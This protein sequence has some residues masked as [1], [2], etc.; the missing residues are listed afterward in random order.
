MGFLRF[1]SR[2]QERKVDDEL[3]IPP[4]PP[5]SMSGID[6]DLNAPFPGDEL[7][8]GLSFP[9][10]A[11]KQQVQQNKGLPSM[12]DFDFDTPSARP[13][14]EMNMQ[15]P[16]ATPLQMSS[17]SFGSQNSQ[18]PIIPA[19]MPAPNAPEQFGRALYVEVEQFRDM[20]NDLTKT[21]NDL[22]KMESVMEHML[23]TESNRD[24]DY[25]RYRGILNDTQR[26]LVF[27]DK[28]LFKG[29]AP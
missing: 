17:S 3:D 16:K 6:S 12:D 20:M 9:N 27:I 8:S 25:A 11:S 7:T 1:L 18:R 19:D 23:V 5:S 24:K 26:K 28:T 2:K 15:V 10:Q 13:M 14:P 21:R 22:K 29:D 4:P